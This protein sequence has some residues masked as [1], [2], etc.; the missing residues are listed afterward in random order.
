MLVMIVHLSNSPLL[1]FY[2]NFPYP[3]EVTLNKKGKE[4]GQSVVRWIVSITVAMNA[5]SEEMKDQ[6]RDRSSWRNSL[7]GC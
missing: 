2:D 4:R 7:C 5:P 3:D 6:L 1:L